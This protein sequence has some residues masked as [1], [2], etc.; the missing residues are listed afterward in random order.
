MSLKSLPGYAQELDENDAFI[1]FSASF[2][3]RFVRWRNRQPGR[4][5]ATSVSRSAS[6][7][8]VP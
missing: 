3:F 4:V 7:R 2:F 1:P 8:P 6:C 5:P